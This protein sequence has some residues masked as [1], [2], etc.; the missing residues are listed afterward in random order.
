MMLG[1]SVHIAVG[2]SLLTLTLG[3]ILA[4][5]KHMKM[6]NVNLKL[7][8]VVAIGASIGMFLGT[9]LVEKLKDLKNLEISI[10]LS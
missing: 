5:I 2:T 7:G 3:I 4:L 1:L 9:T 8:F 6:S 10:N